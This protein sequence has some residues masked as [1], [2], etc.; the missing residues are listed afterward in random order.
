MPFD[1]GD[2]ESWLEQGLDRALSAHPAPSPLA[3]QA[4]YHAAYLSGGIGLTSF[5][6]SVVAAL[7]SKA[8]IAGTTAALVVGGGTAVAAGTASGSVNPS[9][10]GQYISQTFYGDPLACGRVRC[11]MPAA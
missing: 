1:G 10:L 9:N 5:G 2:F 7:T 4:G 6:S 11:G 8:A 3:T